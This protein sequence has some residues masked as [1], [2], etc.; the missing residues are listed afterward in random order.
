MK[1]LARLLAGSLRFWSCLVDVM[2]MHMVLWTLVCL[3]G[4]LASVRS[5]DGWMGN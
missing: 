1:E 4:C 2:A 5:G 3:C